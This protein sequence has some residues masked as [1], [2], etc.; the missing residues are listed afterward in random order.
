MFN[1]DKVVIYIEH[2]NRH[3]KPVN[4]SFFPSFLAHTQH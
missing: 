1:V 3:Y 4:Y 2:K